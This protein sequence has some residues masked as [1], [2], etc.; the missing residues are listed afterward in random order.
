M[1]PPPAKLLTSPNVTFF[2]KRIFPVIW[3]GGLAAIF[4]A[5]LLK[6]LGPGGASNLPFLAVPVLMAVISYGFLN[7]LMV[8]LVDEVFD[9]GDALLVRRGDREERIALAD[10]KNVNYIP[11]MSPPQVTLSLRR[12]GEFGD[13]II[14]CAPLRIVPQPSS[15]VID[16][17]INRIDAA[18]QGR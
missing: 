2:Y 10:I 11:Y 3:F 12:P 1:P 15:P 17:L 6:V 5:G 8:N 16:D 13:T 4:L 18:R 9:A 7:K 14:F